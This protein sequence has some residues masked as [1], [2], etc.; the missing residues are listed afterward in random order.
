MDATEPS[1]SL[2]LCPLMYCNTASLY[3]KFNEFSAFVLVNKPSIILVSETWLNP[4]LPVAL[5]SLSG[6]HLF[7]KDRQF[8]RGGGVCIYVS[9][10]VMSNFTITIIDTPTLNIESLVIKLS[11]RSLTLALGCIYRAPSTDFVSDSK[12]FDIISNLAN[13]YTNLLIFG[14]FNMPDL[15]WPLATLVSSNPSYQLLL[16]VLNDSHL[17]QLVTQP[18]RYRVNQQPS[19][20]DLIISSSPDLLSN[21]EFT[22]PIGKSDH[23]TIMANLQVSF[24]T[25]NRIISFT[26]SITNYRMLENDLVETNWEA[27]L[28]HDTVEENWEVFKSHLLELSSQNSV[29]RTFTRSAKKPWINHQI[30]QMVRRKKILWKTYKRTGNE[31]DYAA[32]RTFSNL[33]ASKIKDSKV[34]YEARLANSKNPK[35]FY[36]YIRDTLGG[37]VRTPQIQNSV[38]TLITENEDIAN[39]FADSFANQFTIEPLHSPPDIAAPQCS[40]SL[41][42]VDFIEDEI[43]VKLQKLKKTKSP[44]PDEISAAILSEYASALA[45]PLSLLMRQSL[46]SGEVPENWRVATVKPIF[47]KGNKLDA[48]NYRPISLTSTVGK[49]MESII[50]DRMME[51]LLDNKVIPSQQHGFIPG[52]SVSSNLLCSLNDW[53][54]ELDSGNPVDVIYFDFSKAFDKVPTRRL[55]H[56]LESVGIRG[57]LLRWIQGFLSYRTFRVKIGSSFS[58]QREVLS[59]VPQG[60][61]LGPLLFTIY[62]ADLAR[63][64]KCPFTLFA[65]DLKV[66][67]TCVNCD[68]INADVNTVSKWAHEW[69]LPLNRDKCCILHL[70]SNNPKLKY[71]LESHLLKDVDSQVDLGITITSDLSWSAHI[72]SVVKKANTVVYLMQKVFSNASPATIAKLHK[73]Y[74][75]PLLEYGNAVWHPVLIRDKQ[76]IESVQRRITRI[77]FSFRRPK[78]EDR[79]K[80]M[81]L[82][83][84]EYR[85]IRGDA[86]TTFKAVSNVGSPIRLLFSISVDFRT[87]GH[88]FKL[89]K[90]NF[91]TRSRQFF[92]PN[93]IFNTWNSTPSHIVQSTSVANFKIAFDAFQT[94]QF[95]V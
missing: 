42:S 27:L 34:A 24:P 61:V 52:R 78:Y 29:S 47:K 86:I 30:L 11:N 51:F 17:C 60:S 14:D 91:R 16:D 69:L 55:L 3:A 59:G 92:L 76:A 48:G 50:N 95:S 44:G 73:S 74:V 20:L 13:D 89:Q 12:L 85:K 26:R 31:M 41:S 93:R 72:L 7:R 66:Y 15:S 75:R 90:E 21:L 2:F 5:I 25:H 63:V 58:S 82:P 83:T 22:S 33:L 80:I 87:R 67:N 94:D 28:M 6:Y 40:V 77:P 10:H 65:D 37:S 23:V 19:V 84:M 88:L 62:T 32:H 81:M 35:C 4:K 43:R 71:Y 38:G 9:D 1:A 45:S 56:K 53:S 54:R 36:K 8:S 70:G 57:S 39:V 18:T 64:I 68:L 46:N 49:V 79:L